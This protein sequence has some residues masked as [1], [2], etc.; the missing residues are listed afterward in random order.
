MEGF[1]PAT[2]VGPWYTDIL[3]AD[4]ASRRIGYIEKLSRTITMRRKREENVTGSVNRIWTTHVGSLV[5]PPRLV[6]FLKKIEAEEP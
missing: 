6:E 4:R 3:R 2:V 1:Q 5:R